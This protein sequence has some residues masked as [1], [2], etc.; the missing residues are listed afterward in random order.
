FTMK[1]KTKTLLTIGITLAGL[2]GVM[3]VVSYTILSRSIAQAEQEGTKQTLKSVLTS[4]SQTEENFSNRFEDWSAWNDTYQFIQDRNQKYIESNLEDLQLK[5]NIFMFVNVTGKKIYEIGFDYKT[6]QNIPVPPELNKYLKPQDLL[7]KHPSTTNNI[8]GVIILNNKPFIINSRPIIKSNN[9]GPIIG[10]LIA[11]KHLDD[12][13]IKRMQEIIHLPLQIYRFNDTNIPADCQ[14]VKDYFL[15]T[16]KNQDTYYKIQDEKTILG[17]ALK[18]DIYG[19]PALVLRVD[20]PRDFHLQGQKSQNSLIISLLIVG[21][22]F[23]A[24]TILL[25]QKLVLN[26]LARLSDEVRYIGDQKD[27]AQ[28]VFVSGNDELSSLG[29]AIN[30]MLTTLQESAKELQEEREKSEKLLLNILPSPIATRLKQ[31]EQTIA[32]SFSEATVLFADIVGFTNISGEVSPAKLVFLLNKI[33]SMFDH[34]AEKHGLE[35]IKTIGDAYM[36]VGGIPTECPNHAESIA[37]MAL[38]M[39]QA[40]AHFNQ[41]NKLDFAIRIGINTGPVVAG[42]IG[43][44]KFIYDLWGDAVN[45]ASRMESHGIPGC[46]QMSQSTY[47]KVK[48]K[49]VIE[50]RGMV[51][52]K[53][54]GE[55]ATYLL[56]SRLPQ[57]LTK[58]QSPVRNQPLMIAHKE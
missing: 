18:K 16:G 38:D 44:K 7:L 19:K 3:Y 15:T 13:T 58:Y 49:F 57:P 21:V 11:A 5:L 27:L 26:R 56:M 17:Y 46:I 28:R 53:G 32:D 12:D 9:E 39:L 34:L 52:V 48:G 22:V 55:M 1:L 24:V 54:K 42:V 23:G 45:I 29:K 8:S 37:E 36:V 41:E 35:K 2:M 31:D 50:R 33:F 6:R 20:I 4:V 43:T 51:Y 10:T 30:W 47:E 40:I 14:A 25:L